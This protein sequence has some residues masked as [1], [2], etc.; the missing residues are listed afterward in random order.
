MGFN[1]NVNDL[2]QDAQ[3]TYRN[4]LAETKQYVTKWEATGLLEG[5]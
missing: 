2:L 3:S 5:D 1:T 4:Q